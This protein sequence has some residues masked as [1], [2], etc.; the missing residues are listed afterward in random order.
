M[1]SNNRADYSSADEWLMAL[2]QDELWLS[3]LQQLQ[4]S[5][6]ANASI[7][8]ERAYEKIGRGETFGFWDSYNHQVEPVVR[9]VWEIAELSLPK[10]KIQVIG[11]LSIEWLEQRSMMDGLVSEKTKMTS[12]EKKLKAVKPKA[13][14]SRKSSGKPMTLKYY[15]HGNNSVLMKQH[16]RVHQV[17]MMW[18]RWGWIDEQTAIDDFDAFFEGEPRYCNI[19]WK[20]SNTTILTILLQEL[21]E[22][23]YIE[24]RTG[25]AAKSLVEQQF[26]K[27]ANSDR[28]RLDNTSE[29]RIKLTLFVLDPQ[30]HDLLFQKFGDLT[31]TQNI[32]EAALNEI[33]E[34]N[35]RLT[36]KV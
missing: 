21:L 17:Y 28:T 6:P 33:F 11:M 19:I 16:K 31:E 12:P 26:G 34:G 20:G 18:N 23:P 35:L 27:T 29:E 30:N 14:D 15:T 9:E 4:S 5:T 2:R 10:L 22:Q 32:Q 24:K 13:K 8:R 1:I 7:L 25:C 36:K 3:Q